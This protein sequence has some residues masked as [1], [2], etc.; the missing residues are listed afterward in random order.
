MK[1][2]LRIDEKVNSFVDGEITFAGTLVNHLEEISRGWNEESTKKMYAKHY[3]TYILPEIPNVGLS[4]LGRVDFEQAL[5]RIKFKGRKKPMSEERMRHFFILVERVLDAAER[6]YGYPNML[7]L[8]AGNIAPSATTALSN[9]RGLRVLH[10]LSEQEKI[11]ASNFLFSDVGIRGEFVGLG[12]MFAC[13]TRP[14]EACGL[15]FGDVVLLSEQDEAY[16]LIISKTSASTLDSLQISGKTRNAPRKIPVTGPL[17]D[18][19]LRRK[20]WVAEQLPAGIDID[21]VPMVCVRNEFTKRANTD[22]I[23]RVGDEFFN[24]IGMETNKLILIRHELMK[25]PQEEEDLCAA[26]PYVLRRDFATDMKALGMNDA[27]LKYVMGH[28]LSGENE[29]KAYLQ[30][31][32]MLMSLRDIMLRRQISYSESQM[33]KVSQ[34]LCIDEFPIESEFYENI[35]IEIDESV[36]EVVA[37]IEPSVFGMEFRIESDTIN[38]IDNVEIDT[39]SGKVAK[40]LTPASSGYRKNFF[41]KARA[42]MRE[43]DESADADD[44]EEL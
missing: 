30:N 26:T 4:S 5:G 6:H 9:R 7:N 43:Y 19:L 38:L 34:P 13:G 42:L 1:H 18:F 23:D 8:S 20:A 17:A 35:T 15:N 27:M 37:V 36:D 21:T 44:L 33:D 16:V 40:E 10:T 41:R 28:D 11:R 39:L 32:D 2:F 3:L 12:I 25:N 31:D 24:A 29:T 22:A 14:A